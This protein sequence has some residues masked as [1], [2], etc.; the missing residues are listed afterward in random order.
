VAGIPF[1]FFTAGYND[2]VDIATINRSI[3]SLVQLVDIVG[4][5]ERY[6]TLP[7]HPAG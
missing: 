4:Y 3:D 2:G 5:R 1:I 6:T 7:S